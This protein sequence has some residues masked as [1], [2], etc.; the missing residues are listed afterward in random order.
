MTSFGALFKVMGRQRFRLMNWVVLG[1][2]AVIAGTLLWRF[3]TAGI[4]GGDTF[5]TVL[6]WSVLALIVAFVLLSVQMERVYTR[7]T[8]RLLPLGETKLYLTDL[9]A[10]VVMFIYFGVIQVVFYLVAEV[11][12]NH[13]LATWLR[14]VSG[15]AYTNQQALKVLTGLTAM[16]IVLVILGWT[17][18][19]F[20]HLAVSSTNNFLPA[21][22]RRLVN[23][24][25]YIVMICLVVWIAGYL[26]DGVNH[27]GQLLAGHEGVDFLV[28]VIGFLVVA[29]IE[30]G[31]NIVFLKKWVETIAN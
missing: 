19:S 4:Q 16:G 2:L 22:R 11:L 26:L 20:V 1:E 14:N 24:V 5:W 3:A 9:L 18:V 23:V 30:A 28:N 7:D 27:V 25:L 10:S 12:D 17:T 6:A 31:L 8:Y 29:A 15:P 21:T 13:Y